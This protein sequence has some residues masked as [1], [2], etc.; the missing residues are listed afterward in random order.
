MDRETS[1]NKGWLG[2]QIKKAPDFTAQSL[3]IDFYNIIR[4]VNHRVC[5]FYYLSARE[6]TSDIDIFV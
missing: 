5:I 2:L 4:L 1:G 3:A 6:D